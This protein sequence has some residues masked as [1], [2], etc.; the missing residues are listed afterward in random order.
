MGWMKALVVGVVVLVPVPLMA[1]PGDTELISILPDAPVVST[2]PNEAAVSLT[3]SPLS[4]D[5]RFIAFAS[6]AGNLVPGDTNEL[7]DVFVRDRATGDTT[8]IS[9]RSNGEQLIGY[10]NFSYVN[11]ISRDGRCLR[12]GS[13]RGRCRGFRRPFRRLRT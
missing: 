7:H 10:P 3:G 11:S 8:R 2:D 1:A 5:G 13:E 12:N 6:F 4:G 9:V